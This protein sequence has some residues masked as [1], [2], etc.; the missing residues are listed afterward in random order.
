LGPAVDLGIS[1]LI[2][3]SSIPYIGGSYALGGD[4][5]IVL[6]SAEEGLTWAIRGSYNYNNVTLSYSGQTFK[7]NS[8]T[9]GAQVLVSRKLSF[10]DPY[11]GAGF[12]Y[13]TGGL[14]TTVTLPVLGDQTVKESGKSQG[15]SFFCG[16]DIKVP[17]VGF[18]ITLE[19]A[20]SPYGMNSLGTKIGF[21]F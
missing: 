9:V 12:Q 15:A 13:V 5:K 6:F 17:N 3:T 2:P 18:E 19:G 7:I 10:A 1:G 11:L 16:V 4:L 21:S 14:Q 8:S 20:Y